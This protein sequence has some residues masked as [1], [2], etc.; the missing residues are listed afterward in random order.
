MTLAQSEEFNKWLCFLASIKDSR[1][2]KELT[3]DC[4]FHKF[5]KKPENFYEFIKFFENKLAK[6]KEDKAK[7]SLAN[8]YLKI[9]SQLCERFGFFEEKQKLDDHC[10][11]IIEPQ[12]YEKIDKSLA[13]YKKESKKLI[14]AVSSILGK[15]LISKKY[16]FEIHGRYK[17][18][19]SIYR[20]IKKKSQDT[21]FSLKDIFAFRI[22]LSNS[23]AK[24]CF[25][26]LNVFHD[27]FSP[28]IDNFKDYISIP[29]IN[30]YQSLHTGLANIIPHLDLPIEVQI[31]T[32]SMHDFAENG[33]AAH[34]V[35]AEEKKSR[36]PT[37]KEKILINYFASLAEDK[38][39]NEFVYCLSFQ[40][41]MFKLKT[42]SSVKD[43]AYQIHT[44]LGN[45]AKSAIVND[46]PVDLGYKISEGDQ[47][48]IVI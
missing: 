15:L 47:I 45:K 3:I 48:K 6:T 1:K 21:I 25:D 41:D 20:K 35:Y 38:S 2:N 42:G 14:D 44:G 5:V 18:I 11:K 36:L 32:K 40:G 19:Y 7:Q 43:F 12:E 26:V 24:Q 28:V 9:L 46:V 33:L 22:I 39:S 27:E 37:E 30:G 17:N 8:Q 31:R 16:T 34:Y 23:S 29:K 13:R 10:F 4:F